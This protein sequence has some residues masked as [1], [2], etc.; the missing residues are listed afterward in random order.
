MDRE[1]IE[2]HLKVILEDY[3]R[4]IERIVHNRLNQVMEQVNTLAQ[5]HNKMVEQM[6][7][8]KNEVRT[9]LASNSHLITQFGLVLCELDALEH[10]LAQSD[11]GLKK[12]L[13]ANYKEVNK[14]AK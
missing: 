5:N 11:E 2:K 10:Y 7:L 1:E 4:R 3:T 14:N 8:L 12:L 13:E 6:N 9:V